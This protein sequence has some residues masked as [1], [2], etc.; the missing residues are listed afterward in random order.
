MGVL[1]RYAQGTNLSC[2]GDFTVGVLGASYQEFTS[3]CDSV[4]YCLGHVLGEGTGMCPE[5]A[6]FW[7]SLAKL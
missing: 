1:S 3:T 6:I 5:A 7:N 2:R 4:S